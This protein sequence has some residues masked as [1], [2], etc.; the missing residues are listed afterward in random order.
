MWQNGAKYGKIWQDGEGCSKMWKNLAINGEMLQKWQNVQKYG[1]IRQNMAKW[2]K[3]QNLAGCGK[4][5][6]KCGKM[7]QKHKNVKHR[8]IISPSK[9][10][11]Q[12]KIMTSRP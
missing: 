3:L 5:V 7:W 10:R 9:S 12:G 11:P 2:E 1:K 4:N 8:K 6:A